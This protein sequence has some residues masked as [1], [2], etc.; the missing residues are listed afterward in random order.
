MAFS[1]LTLY[2]IAALF[3][4]IF[5]S[6]LN[7][8]IARLPAHKS[9][10]MP[11]SRCLH[12]G[13]L[14]SWYDNIPI[15]SYA[16]LRGRCR[17]CHHQISPVYPLVEI[18]TACL[19][20]AAIARFGVSGEFVKAVIFCMLMVVVI[21]TDYRERI[22]PHSVT[23]FGIVVGLI[24]S[25]AIPVNDRLFEWI[26]GRF[27]IILS[28]WPSSLIGALTGGIFGAG[29]LYGVAWF[30]RRFGDPQKEYLGFGD[31]MLMLAIG[32]FLGI[33]LTYLTILLGS[34]AG[35]LVAIS[36]R[37]VSRDFRGYQWP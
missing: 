13:K 15:L 30:F 17:R 10:V 19:F 18:V 3:G 5:G 7:V 1:S 25:L 4:L 23:V 37:V 31:V 32:V 24:L 33:P 2:L 16:L 11:R 9:I 34:L 29:L 36:L 14:I 6:F 12:C 8:C 22:I 21:F 27:G 28:G 20:V 35:T 26:L